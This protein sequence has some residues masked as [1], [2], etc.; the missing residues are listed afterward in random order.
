MLYMTMSILFR[1][2]AS[3]W[4]TN[5]TLPSGKQWTGIIDKI[6]R[7]YWRR[8]ELDMLRA[9]HATAKK[10]AGK[11]REKEAA[12]AATKHARE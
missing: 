11:Q 7:A 10:K 3:S 5:G 12:E 4:T 1:S 6:K 8:K 2:L 9:Q